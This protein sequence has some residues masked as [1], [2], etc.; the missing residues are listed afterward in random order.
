MIHEANVGIGIKGKEGAQA[1]L[2]SDITVSKFNHL[3]KLILFHGQ[4][5]YY[6]VSSAAIISIFKSFAWISA[7]LLYQA[8]CG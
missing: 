3:S 2:A 7:L 8:I 1:S 6:R 5:A 4:L